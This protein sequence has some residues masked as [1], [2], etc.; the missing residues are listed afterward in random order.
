MTKI[1]LLYYR[2]NW[3]ELTYSSTKRFNYY[4]S[5]IICSSCPCNKT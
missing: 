2:P 3:W 1:L 5:R 4:V